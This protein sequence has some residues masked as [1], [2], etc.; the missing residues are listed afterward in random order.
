[1]EQNKKQRNKVN[2]KKKNNIAKTFVDSFP[3]KLHLDCQSVELRTIWNLPF[4]ITDI[5]I[6]LTWFNHYKTYTQKLKRCLQKTK[7]NIDK[8]KEYKFIYFNSGTKLTKYPLE[9]LE[10]KTDR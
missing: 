7:R 10:E 3:L 9:L 8:F 6:R 2:E 4:N 1:M 5:H